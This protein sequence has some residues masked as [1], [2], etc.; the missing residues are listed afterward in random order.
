MSPAIVA[1]RGRFVS[2]FSQ[3]GFRSC[4]GCDLNSGHVRRDQLELVT[5]YEAQEQAQ[6]IPYRDNRHLDKLIGTVNTL[7]QGRNCL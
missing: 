4:V 3:L 6:G 1:D 5:L 2:G 7:H